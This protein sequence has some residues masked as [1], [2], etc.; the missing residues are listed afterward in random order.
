LHACCHPS[1]RAQ[2]SGAIAP[3]S[4]PQDEACVA[5]LLSHHRISGEV[6][7]SSARA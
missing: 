4:A 2:V 3:Q 7:S 1:S 5:V 6:F